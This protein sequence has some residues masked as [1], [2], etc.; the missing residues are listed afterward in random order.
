MLPAPAF[1]LAAVPAIATIGL[2]GVLML[3]A[4]AKRIVPAPALLDSFELWRDHSGSVREM[5]LVGLRD[6]LDGDW[7]EFIK[8]DGTS[9]LQPIADL[10]RAD[11]ER[12]WDAAFALKPV[13]TFK[14]ARTIALDPPKSPNPKYRVEYEFDISVLPVAR[15]EE[16]SLRINRVP[17]E[18]LQGM[19]IHPSKWQTQVDR[20]SRYS[21]FFT[22]KDRSAS[23]ERD[24]FQL[25]T[26]GLFWAPSVKG[27]LAEGAVKA[28]CVGDLAEQ[29]VSLTVPPRGG[30]A[31]G[32]VGPIRLSLRSS[33][34]LGELELRV[35]DSSNG[36]LFYAGF[37]GHAGLLSESRRTDERR[38][39]ARREGSE[40]Q[41]SVGY[42][43]RMKVVEVPFAGIG[44]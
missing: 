26:T 25:V 20:S 39:A 8:R 42:Y 2:I 30:A 12:A 33:G 37:Y 22:G 19:T 3:A 23:P 10:Q 35:D 6:N 18:G 31:T 27:A 14:E 11:Q 24:R 4:S 16:D 15:V 40:V 17:V 7:A 44:Q 36:G 28:V 38:I 1:V 9:V 32:E 34:V 41:V 13:F 29:I 21:N 43:R 5:K